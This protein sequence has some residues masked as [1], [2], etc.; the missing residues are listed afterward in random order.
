MKYIVSK[1]Q[2]RSKIIKILITLLFILMPIIDI[3]RSTFIKEIEILDI[4]IIEYINF[5]LIGISFVLTIP[6]INKKKKIMLLTYILVFM[7]YLYF[8]VINIYKFDINI[9]SQ[10]SPNYIIEL[11]Y[12]IRVYILPILLIIVLFSNRDIFNKEYYLK[13]LKYII[14][15]ISGLI[16]VCN[17]IR[18]SYSSYDSEIELINRTNFFDVFTYS[19]KYKELLTCGLYNSANQISIILFMLLPLNLY[20]LYNRREIG[21]LILV[22]VQTISMII[23][24][25][26]VAALGSCL[27]LIVILL[28]YLFFIFIRREKFDKK[29]FQYNLIILVVTSFVMLISPFYQVMKLSIS[30]EEN[31][32]NETKEIINYAYLKLDED[33]SSD[34]TI[35]LLTKYNGVFKIS[36]TFYELYP[37]EEDIDFWKEVAKRDN[38]LNNDYRIIKTDILKR[39][40]L[41]NGNKLDKFFGIGYTSNFVDIETDY[42]YQYYLFGIIG[43]ILLIGVYVYF[44]IKN[45]TKLFRGKYLKYEYSLRIISSFLGLVGCIFS[46]HLF[47]WSS[48]MIVLATTLCI[49]RVND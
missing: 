18:F 10:A 16:I 14:L 28:M 49:G 32:Q 2:D 11:Y 41:R 6:K 15:E 22:L 42:I 9:F 19:G 4:S 33:M 12:I 38:R 34:E 39:V 23:I 3:L 20:N 40:V 29:Y 8:H 27:V 37:I 24:G 13:I 17:M 5:I 25:T 7:F 44:Y 30:S 26:R 1:I 45:I 48:S 46:G 35:K 36:S 21:S 31:F 43:S 47:G